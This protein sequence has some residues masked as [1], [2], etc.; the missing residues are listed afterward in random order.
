MVLLDFNG[1]YWV[2]L[3]FTGFYQVLLGFT[4]FYWV[5][6]SFTGFHCVSTSFYSVSQQ[7]AADRPSAISIRLMDRIDRFFWC[8]LFSHFQSTST[9]AALNYSTPPSII[10]RRDD[11][12]KQNRN[13]T[14]A[15]AREGD[16]NRNDKNG[17]EEKKTERNQITAHRLVRRRTTP[18]NEPRGGVT[19]NVKGQTTNDRSVNYLADNSIRENGKDHSLTGFSWVQRGF[20]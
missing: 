16:H 13:K 12:K 20:T 3:G 5:L 8:F 11:K 1:F 6:P 10:Q 18:I 2:L 17:N 14:R 7:E 19:Q 9:A 4:K 15:P